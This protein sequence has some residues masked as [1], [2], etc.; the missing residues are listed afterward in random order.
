MRPSGD[1]APCGQKGRAGARGIR[2]HAAR[3]TVEFP[4]FPSY[5]FAHFRAAQV[6][7]VLRTPGLAAVVGVSVAP[8]AI[9]DGENASGLEIDVGIDTVERIRG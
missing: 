1:G 6:H 2:A 7:D 8:A 5:V 3:G 4:L 9:A